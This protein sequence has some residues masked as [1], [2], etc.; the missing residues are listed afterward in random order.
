MVQ[1]PQNGYQMIIGTVGNEDTSSQPILITSTQELFGISFEAGMNVRI[2][3]GTFIVIS[4]HNIVTSAAPADPTTVPAEVMATIFFNI[5][6]ANING[7]LNFVIKTG[8]LNIPINCLT[9]ASVSWFTGAAGY[10][11]S[12]GDNI[13]VFMNDVPNPSKYNFSVYFQ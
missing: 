2:N 4:K 10:N 11:V 8:E 5:P 9:P 13:T 1:G 7:P 6:G 12:R 3:Q